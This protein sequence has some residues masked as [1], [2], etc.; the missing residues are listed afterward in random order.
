MVFLQNMRLER[1]LNIC[2]DIYK[3]Y[4]GY[5]RHTFRSVARCARK[6]TVR[7]WPNNVTLQLNWNSAFRNGIF[8]WHRSGL[9]NSGTWPGRRPRYWDSLRLRAEIGLWTFSDR[10]DPIPRICSQLTPT[11][12]PGTETDRCKYDQ[13]L[14]S[15]KNAINRLPIFIINAIFTRFSLFSNQEKLVKWLFWYILL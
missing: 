14:C 9:R 12:T 2:Y 10:S 3:M 1:L 15:A 7:L 6:W 4:P 5:A 13:L 11:G 8:R